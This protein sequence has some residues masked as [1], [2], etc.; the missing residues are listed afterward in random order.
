MK[1]LLT[2]IALMA[3]LAFSADWLLF[4]F[5][6]TDHGLRDILIIVI[7]VSAFITASGITWFILR[8]G[9]LR[10]IKG[11]FYWWLLSSICFII[12]AGL[13]FKFAYLTKHLSNGSLIISGNWIYASGLFLASLTGLLDEFIGPRPKKKKQR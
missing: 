9:L 3:V 1:K 12:M 4:L 2:I 8:T 13:T 5:L 7:S 6:G 10:P 11:A